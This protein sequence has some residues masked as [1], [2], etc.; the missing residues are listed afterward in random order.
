VQLGQVQVARYGTGGVGGIGGV[1]GAGTLMMMPGSVSGVLG[2]M[3]V[4]HHVGSSSAYPVGQLGGT[5]ASRRVDYAA[6]PT[7]SFLHG[8]SL[9][10]PFGDGLNHGTV[11]L[12]FVGVHPPERQMA[13]M[14]SSSG[15]LRGIDSLNNGEAYAG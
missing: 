15:A 13:W 10:Q 9:G 2:G 5:M 7:G 1:G 14:G 6:V 11:P 8:H 12:S 4:G 3:P